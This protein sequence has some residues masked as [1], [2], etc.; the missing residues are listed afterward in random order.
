MP[1]YQK[2]CKNCKRFVTGSVC[3][4]CNLAEFSRSWKGVVYI[5]DPND[6]EIAKILNI[7]SP[8]RYALWVK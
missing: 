6:S 5:I 1:G 2:V 4:A 3:P 7:K 8:G